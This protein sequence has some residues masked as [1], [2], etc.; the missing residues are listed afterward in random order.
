MQKL[1]IKSFD[2]EAY[3]I[4]EN[5]PIHNRF[6]RVKANNPSFFRCCIETKVRWSVNA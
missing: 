2:E 3:I 4:K 6:I 5:K 1:Y